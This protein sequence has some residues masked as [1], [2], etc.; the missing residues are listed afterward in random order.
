MTL[1]RSVQ[2]FPLLIL[3]LAAAAGV[4]DATG[5]LEPL[6]I[7]S[8]GFETVNSHPQ[9]LVTSRSLVFALNNSS[10]DAVSVLSVELFTYDPT[11]LRVFVQV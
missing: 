10:P 11:Q 1:C 8:P 6:R 5:C 7:S 3:S 9:G 2:V 4:S